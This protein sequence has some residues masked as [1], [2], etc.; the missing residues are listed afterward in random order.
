MQAAQMSELSTR[1]WKQLTFVKLRG[2]SFKTTHA[3]MTFSVHISQTM[4]SLY[5]WAKNIFISIQFRF[6]CLALNHH[7]DHIRTFV[8]TSSFF[9]VKMIS[10][11]S[12]LDAFIEW[13]CSHIALYKYVVWSMHLLVLKDYTQIIA[14]IGKSSFNLMGHIIHICNTCEIIFTL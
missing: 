3:H 13:L 1:T 4:H 12:G 14:H 2:K 5:S 7:K 11:Y 9:T 8:H 10:D 6:N